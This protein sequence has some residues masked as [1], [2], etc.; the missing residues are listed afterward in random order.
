MNATR[1]SKAPGYDN[2]EN[3]VLKKLPHRR[4]MAILNVVNK[5]LRKS[6]DRWKTLTFTASYRPISLLSMLSKAAERII[7][8]KL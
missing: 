5:M 2:I 6:P 7:L 1:T 4:V 8:K 3:R